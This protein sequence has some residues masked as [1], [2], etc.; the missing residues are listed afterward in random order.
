LQG[1]IWFQLQREIFFIGEAGRM[2]FLEA[3]SKVVF[4]GALRAPHF[5]GI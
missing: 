3:V 2:K 1:G 5:R 4:S